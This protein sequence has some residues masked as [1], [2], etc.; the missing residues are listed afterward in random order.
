[1][2]VSVT[3]NDV[4]RPYRQPALV[5]FA[6]GA[7]SVST[8]GF[9]QAQGRIATALRAMQICDGFDG[10][11]ADTLWWRTDDQYAPVTMFVNCNDLFMWGCSDCEAITAENVEALALAVA[12]IAAIDDCEV[13]MAGLLWVSRLRGSRP[14]GAYYKSIDKAL[15]P[16]FDACG[17]V[18]DAGFGNPVAH[19]ASAIEARSDATPESGA[20]E[21][22][23]AVRGSGDAQPEAQ[24]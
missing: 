7:A 24:S 21:G 12:D 15:W 13:D 1:M 4:G 14:Q 5:G 8:K 6:D 11:S 16:L 17:P 10:P 19:P 22:E 23:S 3:Q 2:T 18:R 9:D 20:A